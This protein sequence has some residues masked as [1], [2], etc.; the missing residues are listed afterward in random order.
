MS[1]KIYLYY[2]VN[3]FGGIT[4]N[5]SE[6]KKAKYHD[7]HKWYNKTRRIQKSFQYNSDPNAKV[8]HHLRDTEEQRKYNDEHYELWGFEIDENGNEHFE[9][10][11]YVAFVTKEEHHKIHLVSDETRCRMCESQ[12]IR[13]K[14]NPVSPETCKKI[15]ESN[16]GRPGMVGKDH[17]MYGKHHTEETRQKIRD[18][19]P[20]QSGEKNPFYGKHHSEET[21][22]KISESG[23]GKHSGENNGMFGKHLTD[24][25]KE[26]MSVSLKAAWTD[27]MKQAARERNSGTNSPLYGTHRSDDTRKKIS[28]ALKGKPSRLKNVPRKEEHKVN[29]RKSLMVIRDKYKEYKRNGGTLSW[30][31]FRHELKLNKDKDIACE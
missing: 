26:K 7:K 30:N 1:L 16:L 21:R 17:P 11:K 29:I 3:L 22:K 18:H 23:K 24:S 4:M 2:V 8:I 10:G 28:N 9:Y 20:D 31:E 14:N 5:Q 6:W 25:H 13:R 15:S 27:E 19:L 12:R